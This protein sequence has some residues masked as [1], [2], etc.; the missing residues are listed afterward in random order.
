MCFVRHHASVKRNEDVEW[1]D[2]RHSAW[3]KER[4]LNYL[5]YCR[6]TCQFLVCDTPAVFLI[7]DANPLQHFLSCA[8][9]LISAG[10]LKEREATPYSLWWNRFWQLRR[11]TYLP[12][13]RTLPYISHGMRGGLGRVVISKVKLFLNYCVEKLRRYVAISLSVKRELFKMIDTWQF[14]ISL[15][16]LINLKSIA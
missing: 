11:L 6:S 9:S 4:N 1:V 16:P 3:E 12:N 13:T 5:T 8:S 7:C 2:L 15:L 10:S 14:C